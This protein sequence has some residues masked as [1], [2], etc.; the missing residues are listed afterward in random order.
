MPK[1]SRKLAFYEV[2]K[3]KF[4]ELM[5][6]NFEKAGKLALKRNAPITVTSSI[7]VYPPAMQGAEFEPFG[8]VS[9]NVGMKVPPISSRKF[10]TE[11]K[12]D[13]VIL[14]DGESVADILQESLELP[15]SDIE[16]A[17]NKKAS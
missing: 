9:F 11:I 6:E 1:P 7:T 15:I 5:Q 2:G 10:S 17:R 16:K 12:K 3:G 8:D 4:A 13:G 14:Q